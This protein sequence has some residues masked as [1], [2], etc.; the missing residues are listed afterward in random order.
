MLK[1]VQNSAARSLAL[2][3]VA[4]IGA[5]SLWFIS[6]AIMPELAREAALG[7]WR[8]GLLSSSVQIGFV[9]GALTMALHGTADR[10]DPRRVFSICALLAAMSNAL[11]IVTTP[12]GDLQILLRTLTGIGLAGV[13]PVGMKIAVGWTVKRRG[14]LVGLLVGALTLG[15][16]SPHALA[17]IGDA[18]WR[19]TVSLASACAGI[20]AGL[21]LFAR[22]GPHH[23]PAPRFSPA[24]LRLAW[25]SRPIRLAY[26]GYLCHMWE[27]YAFWAWIAAAL[28]ASLALAN[29]ED[30]AQTARLATFAAI[31][32]GGVFCVPAG[33]LADRIGKARVAGGAMALSATFAFATALSFGGP[34]WLTIA[35][36]VFWGIFVIPDSAQFSALVADAAPADRAGSLMTFQTALGFLLTAVTIQSAPFLAESF[37]WSVTLTVFGI[38]PL[39]GVEAMRRLARATTTAERKT[40]KKEASV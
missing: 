28:S 18:N 26:A 20:S 21:I 22:L 23:V 8:A 12:G 27:L 17:L 3:V 37:G 36:A 19:M 2:L 34:A 5:M 15:S 4:E 40:I 11:L 31:G 32:L 13:Y 10:Y 33:A 25:T 16:A 14:L 38:G 9:L 29:V 7:S 35:L 1:A 39:L 24:S 6:A 30:P